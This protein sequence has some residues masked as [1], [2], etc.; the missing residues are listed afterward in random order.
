MMTTITSRFG[1]AKSTWNLGAA[2]RYL[3]GLDAELRDARPAWLSVAICRVAIFSA[4]Y[5]IFYDTWQIAIG[6]AAFPEWYTAKANGVY[7]PFG[8]L[9]LLGPSVPSFEFWWTARWVA[10]ISTIAAIVGFV[11]RPMMILSVVSVMLIALL[12]ISNSY[13]WS[14][15]WNVIFLAA[16]PFS[17]CK[18][19]SSLSIDRIITIAWPAWRFG[20]RNEPVLW[21]VLAAQAA[22]AFFLFAAFWAKIFQ[23]FEKAGW[24]GPWYYVFSDNMRNILGVFWLGVPENLPPP[25]IEWAWSTPV[26][27]KLLILGHLVMQ[28]V[29]LL[30]LVSLHRPWARLTEGAIFVAGV[31]ALGVIARGWNW[32]WF[33]LLAVFVDWDYFL[34]RR[35]DA[36]RPVADR[37][38]LTTAMPALAVF[39]A[40]YTV[41][42]VTQRANSWGWYPFSN[43]SFYAG[44]YIASPYNE[45]KPYA[46]YMIGEVT[47]RPPPGENP[48]TFL[49]VR[50][51][52]TGKGWSDFGGAAPKGAFRVKNGEIAFPFQG[53]DVHGLGR[54]TDLD[55]L[56][57][58]LSLARYRLGL[59]NFKGGGRYV[60]WLT[61]S[62][63]PAYPEPMGKK[64]LHAGVRGIWDSETQ[65]FVGLTATLD[66][67]AGLLKIAD[68][69]G[70]TEKARDRKVFARFNAH[71]S[72]E[73]QPLLPVPGEWID[74]RTF[75]LAPGF[76]DQ[77]RGKLLNSIVRT[78]TIFG[79]I[80]FDGP[81]QW[82]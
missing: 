81:V 24:L 19:G 14:H 60:A 75:Q 66:R 21:G 35:E 23:T 12:Q 69:R 5:Y 47:L 38:L 17:L 37:L 16:I 13:F 79:P 31:V 10:Q 57:G 67:D 43:M 32:A 54:E 44:L 76:L 26:A 55:R 20:H 29:P 11:T 33:P 41:G 82:L 70:E 15:N 6:D 45:H 59:E 61:T 22:V 7:H 4:I 42:W 48:S 46:D 73:V 56:K 51:D 68:I 8:P 74:E 80:D 72:N 64:I 52:V 25:W 1:F 71:L 78:E 28:A 18:A 2:M 50:P 65:E 77:Y 30:A 49:G 63:F 40:I 3:V 27:W 36:S 34:R 53:N 39:F 9:L 58:G 62:G